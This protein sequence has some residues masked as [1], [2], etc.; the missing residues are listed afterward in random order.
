MELD[1]LTRICLEALDKSHSTL[2]ALGADGA[3][4]VHDDHVVDISTRGDMA[5]SRALIDFFTATGLP[6]RVLSE[7]AEPVDLAASPTYTI[8]FD[9]IDGT[10]NYARGMGMLPHCT[11]V[12]LFDS[13]EPCYRDALVAGVIEHVSG[14]VW[15]AVRDRGCFLDGG[16]TH[17]SGRR[18][19]DRRTVTIV[20]HY[21]SG[22]DLARFG[23]IY[24]RAWVKD[25]GSSALHLA[26]VSSGMFD[27]FL[28]SAQKG[29]E[30][31]AGYLLIREAGGAVTD[32]EGGPLHDSPYDFDGRRPIVAAATPELAA[33]LLEALTAT[34]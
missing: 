20:D 23:P 28:G 12:C 2:A 7:E 21:G 17:S 32:W 24:P 1:V 16:P 5:V 3:D 13:P 25:Y 15:H 34:I 33:V 26:G 27:A 30:L 31:G 22:N 8:A 29:H 6:A 18:R 4:E 9:D 14:C 19:L 11:L 10:D